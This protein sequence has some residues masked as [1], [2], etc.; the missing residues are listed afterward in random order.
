MGRAD[1]VSPRAA[2]E[3]VGPGRALARGACRANGAPRGAPPTPPGTHPRGLTHF[4]PIG[5]RRCGGGQETRHVRTYRSLLGPALSAVFLVYVGLVAALIVA[6]S[7]VLSAARSRAGRARRHRRLA[8][9]CRGDGLRRH[10]RR[11]DPDAAGRLS[12]PHTDHRLHRASWSAARRPD[13]YLAASLPLGLIL[14]LQSFRIGVELTLSSL[15]DA[16]LT[17]AAADARRRQCRNS[18]RRQ[19]AR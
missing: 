6:R 8:R 13:G 17:H 2:S 15:H 7:S 1:G 5:V 19:R 10:R 4:Q 18:G 14:A 3:L 9:L 11:H 12:P 16:G